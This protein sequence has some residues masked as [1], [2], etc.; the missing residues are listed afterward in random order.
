MKTLIQIPGDGNCLFNAILIGYLNA[1]DSQYPTI[2]GVEIRTQEQLRKAVQKHYLKILTGN[3]HE[4]RQ[5]LLQGLRNE[6]SDA[7]L[8]NNFQGFYANNDLL[9]Q[10]Q[11]IRNQL[12]MEPDEGLRAII[13]LEHINEDLI[14]N[15]VLSLNAIWGGDQE[16]NILR[17]I[18]NTKIRLSGHGNPQ[19][20][21]I[22][23]KYVGG[24]H[25]HVYVNDP[26]NNEVSV[27]IRAIGGSPIL[28]E[29]LLTEEQLLKTLTLSDYQFHLFLQ[30]IFN[31]REA[32]QRDINASITD[33]EVNYA[34]DFLVLCSKE[35]T[36][37]QSTIRNGKQIPMSPI[38]DINIRDI[39]DSH[40]SQATGASEFLENTRLFQTPLG[41]TKINLDFSEQIDEITTTLR[42]TGLE[43]EGY[44]TDFDDS[45]GDEA[46]EK[47]RSYTINI[48]K[49]FNNYSFLTHAFGIKLLWSPEVRGFYR[50]LKKKLLRNDVEITKKT[51]WPIYEALY[52][53]IK[54]IIQ[55]EGFIKKFL[56]DQSELIID[57]EN[58]LLANV[59]AIKEKH[60]SKKKIFKILDEKS[61]EIFEKILINLSDYLKIYDFRNLAKVASSKSYISKLFEKDLAVKLSKFFDLNFYLS[62]NDIII[63]KQDKVDALT[64]GSKSITDAKITKDAKKIKKIKQL[65]LDDKELQELSLKGKALLKT[66]QDQETSTGGT[67]TTFKSTNKKYILE[68]YVLLLIQEAKKEGEILD[69]ENNF[70]PNNYYKSILARENI[71]LY[72]FE[73]GE[74]STAPVNLSNLQKRLDKLDLLEN[75]LDYIYDNLVFITTDRK[76]LDAMHTFD[77]REALYLEESLFPYYFATLRLSNRSIRREVKNKEDAKKSQDYVTDSVFLRLWKFIHDG[78]EYSERQTLNEYLT[79]TDYT[80]FGT[81]KSNYESL[82]SY[83]IVIKE[84]L[85]KQYQKVDNASIANHIRAFFSKNK[86]DFDLIYGAKKV[87]TIRNLGEFET[88]EINKMLARITGLIFGTEV[89]RNPA[90][91]IHVQMILDLIESGHIDFD[92]AFNTANNPLLPMAPSES[93]SMAVT[94]N[95]Y[96]QDHMPY[97][98]VHNGA[99]NKN[100]KH[101]EQSEERLVKLWAKKIAGLREYEVNDVIL[102]IERS[103]KEWFGIEVLLLKESIQV[104]EYFEN[105]ESDLNFDIYD[106]IKNLTFDELLNV[107]KLIESYTDEDA[108]I[109]LNWYFE[110]NISDLQNDIL[111]QIANLESTELEGLA[112]MIENDSWGER[113]LIYKILDSGLELSKC[114]SILENA[115]DHLEGSS[116]AD[117]DLNDITQLDTDQL[118]Q[119][120]EMI[121]ED[122]DF[123]LKLNSDITFEE[124]LEIYSDYSNYQEKLDAFLDKEFLSLRTYYNRITKSSISLEDFYELYK[125][126]ENKLRFLLDNEYRCKKLIKKTGYDIVS[127]AFDQV[128]ED[129]GIEQDNLFD[130]DEEETDIYQLIYN[131]LESFEII[132]SDS[133]EEI[134]VNFCLL[135][136]DNEILNNPKGQKLFELAAKSKNIDV[137]NLLLELGKNKFFAEQIILMIDELGAEEVLE[138]L[139]NDKID[140]QKQSDDIAKELDLLP[141]TQDQQNLENIAKIEAIIGRDA[142]SQITG[143]YQY[144]S[145]ALSNGPYAA[146]SGIVISTVSNL[147]QNLQD[148][149]DLSSL[150]ESVNL[151][152]QVAILLAQLDNLLHFVASGPMLV[153]LPPKPPYFDPDNDNDYGGFGNG[154]NGIKNDGNNT[155]SE[156]IN[157]PLYIGVNSTFIDT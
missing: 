140:S 70:H 36:T 24:H 47:A 99:D 59:K 82:V 90:T 157:I 129:E 30:I 62:E 71:S 155:Y 143:L 18:L 65:K 17:N 102:A 27:L 148:M 137:I 117:F 48:K 93:T 50:A 60:N 147:I 34:I 5:E 104:L 28:D 42:R 8:L 138:T 92:Q 35:V 146:F 55:N 97:P 134:S 63:L 72:L 46:D 101:L 91:L 144:I 23:L 1:H 119:L 116:E 83:I 100:S 43:D 12:D 126:N 107:A 31:K 112:R 87:K 33:E 111:E 3:N 45:S 16:I 39:G 114:I 68:C 13:L 150:Y 123:L 56:E 121:S 52:S 142:S 103:C 78:A 131:K 67:F 156:V 14:S 37:N 41:K 49:Q 9:V 132:N 154:G 11:D 113:E 44:Y 2:N 4:L 136:Y 53:S 124:L 57:L 40:D 6:L 94:L 76:T 10:L 64:P 88:K 127:E 81:Q 84:Q 151:D 22:E 125:G 74:E 135:K 139:F 75:V 115:I 85:A 105:N 77:L 106:F 15:Y 108:N 80:M 120:D 79:R 19:E 122:K 69:E 7:I 130:I 26:N 89:Q 128:C 38:V 86:L 96:F 145:S 109:I 20:N 54:K 73:L 133:D 58:I 149:L 110:G 61:R 29:S 25:Y 51:K 66:V 118:E 153:G 32:E 95:K 141:H 152:S 21:E 98:Y